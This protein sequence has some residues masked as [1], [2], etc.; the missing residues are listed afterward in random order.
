MYG[1]TDSPGHVPS[2]FDQRST[3]PEGAQMKPAA[4]NRY[5]PADAT[6]GKGDQDA[7]PHR[8][9]RFSCSS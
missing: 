7:F 8:G 2:P 3:S 4:R 9:E 5:D 6:N 1:S